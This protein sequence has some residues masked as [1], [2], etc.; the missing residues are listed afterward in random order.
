[1]KI[2]D[3]N[4]FIKDAEYFFTKLFASSIEKKYGEIELATFKPNTPTKQYFSDFKQAAECAYNI[5]NQ[6][7]D[8]YTGVNPRVGRKS[9]KENIH[10]QSAFHADVD[11]GDD[12]HNKK[13]E[14][15]DSQE[16]IDIIQ[17]YHL[18]PSYLLSSGG[19]FH[20]FWVLNNPVKVSDIGIDEI[21]SI[22][23]HLIK[24]L[25]GDVGTQNIN[26]HLRIPG[27]FNFKPDY[28]I[29]PFV[30]I[31]NSDGPLYD[32]EDFRQFIDVKKSKSKDPVKS[33]QLPNVTVPLDTDINKIPVSDKIKKLIMNGNDGSYPSRSE[34]D[35][36]VVMTLI[37]KGYEKSQISQ[38][39]DRYAI[40]DKYREQKSPGK[41]LEHTIKNA[42]KY[43]NLTD[44]ELQDPLFISGA[45]N[46]DDKGNFSFNIVKF[47]EFIVKKYK[48]KYFEKEKAFF[49]YNDYCYQQISDEQLNFLCQS[50]LKEFKRFFPKSAMVNFIHFA[51]G[52]CLINSLEA[53]DHQK[54]FLTLKNG[55]YD[56]NMEELVPH[57]PS[58][59]TTNLL[60]YEFDPD[61]VCPLWEKFL[62]DVFFGKQ[63]VINF[64]KQAVGY[65]FL[66]DIPTAALFLLIGEG[67]NGKSVFINTTTNL[68]G[69]ENVANVNLHQMSDEYYIQDLF[70]KMVNLSAESSYKKRID[71]EIIKAAVAGDWI[72]GRLPYKPPSKFKP[73]AKHFLSINKIPKNDD[74]SYGWERRIY[75][76]EFNRLFAEKDADKQ[77]TNKLKLE[78]SG[79][80]NWALEGY[81]SL[82]GQD[83]VFIESA[84]INQA[85][86]NYKTQSNSVHNFIASTLTKSTDSN[87][88]ISLKDV[89][90]K[91][92]NFCDSEGEKMDL[93]KPE[94]KKVLIQSGYPVKNSTKHGNAVCVFGA[95][96]RGT[97]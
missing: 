94:L 47:V 40:G 82:R 42:K 64:V 53:Y 68:F 3:K 75:P 52:S 21:E 93:T 87:N 27:T 67:S 41:Y 11:F 73:Y 79:I 65:S 4:K 23:L 10:Y 20:C 72:S 88:I 90:D 56:L 44:E 33:H 51:I 13:S 26:R 77:M 19:G 57:D 32:F 24:S 1:M 49:Q 58:V 62:S 43:S 48:F 39:F 70:G 60:P 38:I 31:V 29:P 8:V 54:R 71:T 97:I 81:R 16:A 96:S 15:M 84:S 18:P 89:Y 45:I 66:K 14:L 7:I 80:F 30:S 9:I 55:L 28:Y 59:F 63:D 74:L 76:I 6:G 22:N 92:K 37:H 69:E 85:K 46:K 34:T 35:M 25:K 86:Q 61:A 83:Y 78:L 36:A 17:K 50:K 95:I 12:G 91:Y 2:E 5:C